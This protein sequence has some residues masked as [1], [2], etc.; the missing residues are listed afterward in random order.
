MSIPLYWGKLHGNFGYPLPVPYESQIDKQT[1]GAASLAMVYRSFGMEVGQERICRET[2]RTRRAIGLADHARKTGLQAA[3]VRLNETRDGLLAVRQSYP[4]CRIIL[5]HRLMT[6][7]SYGH[8][9]VVVDVE[10]DW[11]VLHD[12]MFG[13][14]RRWTP[15]TLKSLWETPGGEIIGK[16]A[17]LVRRSDTC[18]NSLVTCPRCETANDLSPFQKILD[19]ATVYCAACDKALG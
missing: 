14:F 11:G 13:P 19:R 3:I 5:N 2:G 7:V 6:G 17:L 4:D 12:P 10:R 9:S 15:E 16:V 1:C 8:Y 18:R